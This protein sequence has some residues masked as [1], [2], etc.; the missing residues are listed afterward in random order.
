MPLFGYNY[1]KP[2]KGVDPNA[3]KKHPFLLFWELIGRKFFKY[4][5]LNIMYFVIISPIVV[6]IYAAF[7]GWLVSIGQ[8]ERETIVSFLLELFSNVVSYI[9][10]VLHL[11]LLVISL[12]LYGPITAGLTYM[13]RNFAREE[14]AFTSDFFSKALENWKQGLVFGILDILAFLV[15]WVNI[16]YSA[17]VGANTVGMELF[18]VFVKYFTIVLFVL[19]LFMRFYTYQMIVTAELSVRAIL[20]NAWLFAI[21]GLGRN[22]IATVGILLSVVVFIFINPV[23]EMFAI[24]LFAFSF[25]RF[26]AVYTTYPIIEKYIIKPVRDA[27]K[28]KA[29]K[30]IAEALGGRGGELPPELGGPGAGARAYE[31]ISGAD[32]R[33]ET[34]SKQDSDSNSDTDSE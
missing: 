13:L 26:I 22:I 28:A 2:G 8:I 9:P 34:D 1:N 27:E 33:S 25:C 19:Y 12:L 6:Y 32:Y 14:H 17:L 21:L 23:I 31:A 24:P 30:D 16:N 10:S 20:K 5:L 15:L 3:P 7:Y 4:V 29:E 11:P 18:G